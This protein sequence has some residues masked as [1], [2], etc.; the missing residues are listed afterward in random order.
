MTKLL[1]LALVV[2]MAGCNK[3]KPDL[4]ITAN[5]V[6][7][8]DKNCIVKEGT[9]FSGFICKNGKVLLENSRTLDATSKQRDEFL[10]QI[11]RQVKTMQ[12]MMVEINRLQGMV[13]ESIGQTE[14][15]LAIGKSSMKANESNDVY[16]IQEACPLS[17]EVTLDI[18]NPPKGGRIWLCD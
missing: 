11:Q 18:K 1:V 2:G 6:P 3:T 14:Q 13:N 17:R 8:T 16:T 10:A 15:C 7:V 5:T 9:Y 4:K 12:K